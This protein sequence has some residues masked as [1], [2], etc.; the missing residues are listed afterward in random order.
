MITVNG[1]DIGIIVEPRHIAGIHGPGAGRLRGFFLHIV[2]HIAIDGNPELFISD[3]DIVGINPEAPLDDLDRLVERGLLHRVDHGYRLYGVNHYRFTREIPGRPVVDVPLPLDRAAAIVDYAAHAESP[4]SARDVGDHF[5]IG[6]KLAGDCLARLARDRRVQRI[7]RGRYT[8]PGGVITPTT[9]PVDKPVDNYGAYA[10]F[11]SNAYA[12]DANDASVS[13]GNASLASNAYANDAS[14]QTDSDEGVYTSR[15]RATRG[16][17]SK[18]QLQKTTTTNKLPTTKTKTTTTTL[19]GVKS[20]RNH[21]ESRRGTRIPLPFAVDDSMREW[22]H[23]KVPTVDVDFET[24][25]FVDHW[26]AKATNATKL[27]WRRAWQTWMRRAVQF[28]TRP[29]D[30]RQT[31]DR[32]EWRNPPCPPWMD[33]YGDEY[34][35]YRAECKAK[36]RRGES[37]GDEWQAS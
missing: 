26:A 18:E 12:S 13:V 23:E 25:C 34:A 22:A 11:A 24:E 15:A 31:P 29:A 27:D 6:I 30:R 10:S 28:N 16:I 36:W 8:A 35:A 21:G 9:G 7:A 3:A 5:G 19:C 20:E 14:A 17:N 1:P 32:P 4:V 2:Y 37:Y 33:I